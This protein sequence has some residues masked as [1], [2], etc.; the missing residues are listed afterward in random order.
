MGQDVDEVSNSSNLV[1]DD[2]LL[3][4]SSKL[5]DQ[6][7]KVAESLGT[8]ADD[9]AH[10]G[11]QLEAFAGKVRRSPGLDAVNRHLGGILTETQNI[12]ERNHNLEERLR[13][14]AAEIAALRRQ[15]E[16]ARET[17]NTDALTGLANRRMFF[18]QLRNCAR[19]A[20]EADEP[21]CL[22][23]V[24]VD[25]FK[26]FNDRHGHRFGD[27]VLKLVAHVLTSNLKGRDLVAR[28]GGE[29][30]AAILPNTDSDDAMNLVETLRHSVESRKIVKRGSKRAI[31]SLTVS[32]GVAAYRTGEDVGLLI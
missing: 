32:I 31:G 26:Q 22:L 9:S 6:I 15:L 19:Q 16:E 18:A 12:C 20:N 5:G 23:M 27:Q 1:S 28:Y 17:A 13:E 24:D 14:S 2:E 30:F 11:K 7:D 29:E 8:A 10:Y 21:L 25:H 4:I 3:E